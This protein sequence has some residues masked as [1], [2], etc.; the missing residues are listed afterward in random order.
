MHPKGDVRRGTLPSR[1]FVNL[2]TASAGAPR[3]GSFHCPHPSHLI[4]G[5]VWSHENVDVWGIG[6]SL[7]EV[8][9]EEE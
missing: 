6:G 9:G 8:K 4:P 3:A 1:G 2:A 5:W 7:L